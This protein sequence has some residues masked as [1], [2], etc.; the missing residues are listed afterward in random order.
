MVMKNK[1]RLRISNRLEETRRPDDLMHCG[2]LDGI[3][4]Q[5]KDIGGKTGRI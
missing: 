4:E 5:R 2:A 3:L 1:G